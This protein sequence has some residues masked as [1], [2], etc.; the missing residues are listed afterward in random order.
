MTQ[1]SELLQLLQLARHA[2]PSS[3]GNS[4]TASSTLATGSGPSLADL[5]A[6]LLKHVAKPIELSAIVPDASI[7]I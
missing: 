1:T 4:G 2:R 6:E 3:S 5:I 7:E